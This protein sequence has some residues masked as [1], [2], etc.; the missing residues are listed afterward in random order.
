MLPISELFMSSSVYLPPEWVPQHAIILGW[1]IASTDWSKQMPLVENLY[2]NLIALITPYELVLLVAPL[3]QHGY[4]RERLQQ[5]DLPLDRVHLIDAPYNDTW[6]RD[7]APITVWNEQNQPIFVDFEF[8][9]WGE[10][11]PFVQDNLMTRHLLQ[12]PAFKNL[13]QL[14][15]AQT[16]QPG[17]ILEGGSIEVNGAGLL[18][19]SKQCLL[20]SNRGARTQAQITEQLKRAL[21]VEEVLWVSHGHVEGDDT[22]SHIDTLARFSAE[23]QVCYQSCDEVDYPSYAELKALEKEL[24]ELMDPRG[25]E[26]IPL[27]WP[28]A[29]YSPEGPRMAATYVNFLIMNQQVIVPQY[30]VPQDAQAI[31]QLQRCFPDRK[32][33]G[34]NCRP[35]IRQGGS[36]HCITMQLP[37]GRR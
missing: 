12:A 15:Q 29:C 31:A 7:T 20:N 24:H 35:L 37:V 30:D 10:K 5:A 4:V 25:I 16:Q 28:D 17:F 27:P 33:V 8:N 18:L 21:G 14:Q 23:K 34:I 19:T 3:D 13:Y 6:M 26:L 11:H 2:L 9:G 32:V 36:L 22:D 1:P